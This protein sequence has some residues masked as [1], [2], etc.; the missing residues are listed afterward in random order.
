[1]ATTN[2][3]Q[4]RDKITSIEK[5]SGTGAAGTTDTYTIKTE[6]S[7]NGAGT[8]TVYNGADG[9]DGETL[10]I[11]ELVFS[12]YP[13]G[14]RYAYDSSTGTFT[15]ASYTP[16]YASK[17][18]RLVSTSPTAVTSLS[19]AANLINGSLRASAGI[20]TSG[21]KIISLGNNGN[22]SLYITCLSSMNSLE[23]PRFYV[24]EFTGS[25]TDTV[26][27]ASNS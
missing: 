1:M 21:Y 4:V 17:Y 11:H 3:G 9:K 10:Y 26:T 7:P 16:T 12:H 2:L 22:T 14:K 27:R 13:S 24:F 19:G 15:E 25:F 20:E 18:I 8:F 23:L 6:C 5:T